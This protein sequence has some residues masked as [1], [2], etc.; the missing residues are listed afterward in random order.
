LSAYFIIASNSWM[1]HPV[2]YELNAAGDRAQATDMLTI[3]FQPFAV[4]AWVH[5]ILAGMMVGGFLVLG[6]SAWHLW[7]GRNVELFELTARLAILVLIPVTAVNLVWGSEFGVFTTDV[8]PMKIAATEALWDTEQ[9]AAFSLFQIGGFSVSDQTPSF[10][11]EVPRL[12]SF[13]S[14]NSFNGEVVGINQLQAQYEQ[15][16]GPGNYIP[17]IPLTYWAM[18]IMAYLGTLS[19]GLALWGGWLLRKGRLTT[20]TWFHKAALVG[21]ALPFVSALAGWVLTEAGR[22]P[23]V[24]WGLLKTEDAVSNLPTSSVVISLSAFMLLYLGLAIAD[25]VLMRHYA[26]LDPPKAKDEPAP[27]AVPEPSPGY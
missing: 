27:S 12:L 22:Q 15:Q 14:T 2:G 1:Q 18:R 9:P 13:L 7:R 23:W 21:I 25:F 10:A 20:A 17:S 16:F 4:V 5:A 26:R 8:Q 24:V 3:L 6:V 19:L 11:I